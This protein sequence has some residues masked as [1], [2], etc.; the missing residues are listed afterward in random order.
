MVVVELL[1]DHLNHM[2]YYNP[3]VQNEILKELLMMQIFYDVYQKEMQ[4]L[5]NKMKIY[6]I[7]LLK[8]MIYHW[9]I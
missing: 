4:I 8:N 9:K 6:L 2:T 1:N 5:I 3:K 7:K